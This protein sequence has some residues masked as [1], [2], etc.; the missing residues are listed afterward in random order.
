MESVAGHA[1]MAFHS[2]LDHTILYYTIPIRL[3]TLLASPI[4]PV[5]RIAYLPPTYLHT[6]RNHQYVESVR[7]RKSGQHDTGWNK[8]KWNDL[9]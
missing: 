9:G 1:C 5:S 8:T 3:S 6:R 7:R 4:I 2:F